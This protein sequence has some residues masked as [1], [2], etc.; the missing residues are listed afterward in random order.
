MAILNDELSKDE[1]HINIEAS[2]KATFLYTLETHV[3]SKA[4][5]F[6][7][8]KGI[9]K[10]EIVHNKPVYHLSFEGDGMKIHTQDDS[11]IDELN[12]YINNVFGFP[13]KLVFINKPIKEFLTA[14]SC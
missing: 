2:M 13:N 4:F 3:I 9:I 8:K 14:R 1:E 7:L 5:H 11:F 6:L 10:T 12:E